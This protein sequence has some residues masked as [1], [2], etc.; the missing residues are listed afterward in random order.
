MPAFYVPLSVATDKGDAAFD[1]KIAEV[2][3]AM[4]SDGTLTKLSEKWYG[5]DLTSTK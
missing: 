5:A 4:R 1:A 3:A 2:V